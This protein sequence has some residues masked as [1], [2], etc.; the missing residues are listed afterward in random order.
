VKAFLVARG[1]LKEGG[2]W[3]DLAADYV[4]RILGNLGG[5][6]KAVDEFQPAGGAA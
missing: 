3:S 6:F 4:S 1:Q 5:F 2:S